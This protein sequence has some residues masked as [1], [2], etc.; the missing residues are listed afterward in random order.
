MTH[1]VQGV[2]ESSCRTRGSQ[3]ASARVMDLDLKTL[4][5]HL[6]VKLDVSLKQ[7]FLLG[8]SFADI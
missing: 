7:N 5:R 3:K 1:E 2:N 8:Q 6:R 4:R